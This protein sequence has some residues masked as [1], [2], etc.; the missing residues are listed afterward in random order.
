MLDIDEC[1]MGRNIVLI[2]ARK[3]FK[4]MAE[5]KLNSISQTMADDQNEGLSAISY[6]P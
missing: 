2:K 5:E 4:L 1:K 3:A 6:N